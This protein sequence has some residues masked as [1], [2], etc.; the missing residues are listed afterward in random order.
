MDAKVED[1]GAGGSSAKL[2]RLAAAPLA[3]A[4][5]ARPQ[6]ARARTGLTSMGS[7][8]LR[9]QIKEASISDLEL[10]RQKGGA[11]RADLATRDHFLISL[12]FH[13]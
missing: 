11:L 6:K 1:G 7:A 9:S 12:I 2:G 13:V 5:K 8:A 4:D 3:C 10:R